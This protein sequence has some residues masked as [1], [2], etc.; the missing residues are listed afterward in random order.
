MLKK[1]HATVVPEG[2]L[3][4]MR[5][6]ALCWAEFMRDHLPGKREISSY[7]S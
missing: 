1:I 5:E 2:K 4:D 3:P 7:R 6:T